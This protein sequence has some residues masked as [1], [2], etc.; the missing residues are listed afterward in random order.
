MREK[1]DAWLRAELSTE[2][3][4]DPPTRSYE[5]LAEELAEEL[6]KTVPPQ[7]LEKVR[8]YVRAM[9]ATVMI[10]RLSKLLSKPGNY[11]GRQNLTVEEERIIRSIIRVARVRPVTE[12]SE[13]SVVMFLERFPQMITSDGVVLGPFEE[14]DI[15]KLPNVDIS[16]LESSGTVTRIKIRFT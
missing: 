16:E 7:L 11:Q 1:L 6:V 12:P 14:G 4:Q 8:E 5:E 10:V 9:L 2:A 3:L 13:Y 15:A